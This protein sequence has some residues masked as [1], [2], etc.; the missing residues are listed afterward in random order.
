MELGRD[1]LQAG[2]EAVWEL[3]GPSTISCAAVAPGLVV[4][5][6]A[7]SQVRWTLVSFGRDATLHRMRAHHPAVPLQRVL[8]VSW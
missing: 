5:A 4:L 7:A 3:P 8:L 2:A 6:D 1:Q